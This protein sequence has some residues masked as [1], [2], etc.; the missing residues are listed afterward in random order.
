MME[1][2]TLDTRLCERVV[3]TPNVHHTKTAVTPAVRESE[4][5]DREGIRWES[6]AGALES[7]RQSVMLNGLVADTTKWPG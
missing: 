7:G 5:A 3:D 4:N 2:R 1:F 6:F